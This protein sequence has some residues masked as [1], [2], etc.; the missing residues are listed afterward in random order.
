M[1]FHAE[2]LTTE[3]RKMWSGLSCCAVP[4]GWSWKLLNFR[5]KWFNTKFDWSFFSYCKS[6]RPFIYGLL[7]KHCRHLL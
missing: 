6:M 2:V 5:W 3:I 7:T 4:S 1:R